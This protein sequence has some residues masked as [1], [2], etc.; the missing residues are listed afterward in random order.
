MVNDFDELFRERTELMDFSDKKRKAIGNY[1]LGRLLGEGTF[2]KVRL[3]VHLPSGERVAVKIIKKRKTSGGR[4]RELKRMVHR[5]VKL[6]R[7]LEHPHVAQLYEVSPIP[8]LPTHP[9][10]KPPPPQTHTTGQAP[11]H[12]KKIRAVKKKIEKKI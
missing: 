3:A 7:R 5:E 10:T 6:H 2:A 9:H 4:Q 11:K 1:V 8:P 12:H